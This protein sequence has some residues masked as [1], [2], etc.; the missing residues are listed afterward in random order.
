MIAIANQNRPGYVTTFPKVFDITRF[1]RNAFLGAKLQK[2]VNNDA[3]NFE[4]YFS[5]LK[6][7]RF[8]DNLILLKYGT[9]V[10]TERMFK[11]GFFFNP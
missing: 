10:P 2:F 4:Q 8:F 9:K 11:K 1:Q 5:N 6:F 3:T 7:L